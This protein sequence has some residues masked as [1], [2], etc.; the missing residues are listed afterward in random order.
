MICTNDYDKNIKS[1]NDFLENPIQMWFETIKHTYDEYYHILTV[2]VWVISEWI[3]DR[4]RWVSYERNMSINK[5]LL[6]ENLIWLPDFLLPHAF[7]K[8]GQQI[9]IPNKYQCDIFKFGHTTCR[10]QCSFSAFC[11]ADFRRWPF[12]RQI[13]TLSIGDILIPDFEVNYIILNQYD[14]SI[15]ENK[16]KIQVNHISSNNSFKVDGSWIIN[17]FV[18][19]RHLDVH[20]LVV[21]LPTLSE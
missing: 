21:M 3:D 10:Q 2:D 9:C 5:L 7:W 19:T 17:E 13:C 18:V 4:L 20:A 12:D 6:K 1:M 8:E 16:H 14:S 15:E 11:T